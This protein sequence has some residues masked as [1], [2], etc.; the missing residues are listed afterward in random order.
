MQ[1]NLD[2]PTK[3]L[4]EVQ[5][6]LKKALIPLME[7]LKK[8]YSATT[9]TM[10]QAEA[11]AVFGRDILTAANT[12]IQKVGLYAALRPAE[13]KILER[14]TRMY[15]D[16]AEP[17]PE[18]IAAGTPV[19]VF[20]VPDPFV[21]IWDEATKTMIVAGR[22]FPEQMSPDE[23][24]SRATMLADQK[25]ASDLKASAMVDEMTEGHG[26]VR[27]NKKPGGTDAPEHPLEGTK[28]KSGGDDINRTRPPDGT[29][30]PETGGGVP[31]GQQGPLDP[32]DAPFRVENRSKIDDLFDQKL[33]SAIIARLHNWLDNSLSNKNTVY[34]KW[35]A[36]AVDKVAG[37]VNPMFVVSAK[38]F[39]MA[40]AFARLQYDRKQ[41]ADISNL[42]WL[43]RSL[44]ITDAD[45]KQFGSKVIEEKNG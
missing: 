19:D 34:E 4:M 38:V 2:K 33:P 22:Q 1:K 25:I 42:E 7:I 28:N 43:K 40:S 15:K 17:D 44:L 27:K 36:Q 45:V 13:R 16:I 9:Q 39:R 12:E 3:E 20:K 29:K 31:R 30:P 5:A 24:L 37:T 10:G 26:K 41:L 8:P 23:I 11:I 35:T 18:A 14:V 21:E 6:E 32:E